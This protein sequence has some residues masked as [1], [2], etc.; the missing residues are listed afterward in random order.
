MDKYTILCYSERGC[1]ICYDGKNPFISEC[2]TSTAT[3]MEWL[4]SHA[5]SLG[6]DVTFKIQRLVEE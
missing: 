5:A 1:E 3:Y 2:L 6:E 4:K